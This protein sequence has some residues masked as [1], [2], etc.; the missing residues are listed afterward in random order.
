MSEALVIKKEEKKIAAAF[1][2]KTYF[3]FSEIQ[4]LL[5]LYRFALI[6]YVTSYMYSAQG[7]DR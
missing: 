5:Q 1:V 6:Q 3:S 7:T 2:K 4:R